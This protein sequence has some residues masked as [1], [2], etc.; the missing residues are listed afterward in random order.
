MDSL[1]EAARY[2]PIQSYLLGV[3]C[4]DDI[5]IYSSPLSVLRPAQSFNSLLLYLTHHQQVSLPRWACSCSRI[6]PSKRYFFPLHHCL[7]C[8]PALGFCEALRDSCDCHR[9]YITKAE[10]LKLVQDSKWP[11]CWIIKERKFLSIKYLLKSFLSY[12]L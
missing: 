11:T 5:C 4:M 1:V 9:G 3:G 10:L 7:F 2:I 12:Q 6:L 8:S